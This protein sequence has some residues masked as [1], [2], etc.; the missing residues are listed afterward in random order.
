VSS[1]L[2]Y[3]ETRSALARARRDARI[4]PH[5]LALARRLFERLW[6]GMY[7]VEAT[8]EIS[9]QAGDL[10]EEHSLRAYDAVHLASAVS[11]A[12][13]VVF[14]AADGDLLEAAAH[15]GLVTASAA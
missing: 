8:E 2:L 6:E 1:I 3:A 14:V 7:R 9:R 10:A 12:E 11:I 4:M 13:N 5:D 15:R